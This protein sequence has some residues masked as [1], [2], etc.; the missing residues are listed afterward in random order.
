MYLLLWVKDVMRFTKYFVIKHTF[1]PISLEMIEMIT[2]PA[3]GNFRQN[4]CQNSLNS[5]DH[6]KLRELSESFSIIVFLTFLQ[7]TA[8][9]LL[10]L[11]LITKHH[12]NVYKIQL[13]RNATSKILT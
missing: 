5:C 7:M 6:D 4:Y 2:M 13:K 10:P 9:S 12:H 8:V 11:V 3:L 1:D